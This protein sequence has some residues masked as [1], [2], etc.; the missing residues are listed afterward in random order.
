[1]SRYIQGLLIALIFIFVFQYIGHLSIFILGS[2]VFLTAGYFYPL[3]GSNTSKIF[4]I[5]IPVISLLFFIAY[6]SYFQQSDFSPEKLL[7]AILY[8]LVTF[9]ISFFIGIILKKVIKNEITGLLIVL[10]LTQIL[11]YRFTIFIDHAWAALVI[12]II[13]FVFSFIL[14]RR[15]VKRKF[16]IFIFLLLPYILLYNISSDIYQFTFIVSILISLN[17]ILSFLYFKILNPLIITRNLGSIV[18]LLLFYFISYVFLLNAKEKVF[19]QENTIPRFNDFSEKFYYSNEKEINSIDFENKVLVLNL[20]TSSCKYCFINFP[21]FN[22]FYNE[23]KDDVEIYSVGLPY[24]GQSI[25]QLDSLIMKFNYDFPVVYS[26][27]S[28]QYFSKKYNVKSVP[29]VLIINKKGNIIFNN[30]YN[31]HPLIWTNNLNKLVE[32]QVSK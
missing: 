30:N 12:S 8:Y 32:N 2:A 29:A 31:F 10:S 5:I 28:L 14:L 25:S 7:R 26:K 11:I 23:F 4:R 3:T 16:Y 27:N 1:M 15:G 22:R 20:W 6:N 13:S 17:L 24:E 21:K 18:L 19:N 9:S